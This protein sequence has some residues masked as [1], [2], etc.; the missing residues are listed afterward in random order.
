[1]FYFYSND[2]SL[3]NFDQKI[4]NFQKELSA[5]IDL[6]YKVDYFLSFSINYLRN[7]AKYSSSSPFSSAIILKF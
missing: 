1:M 4:E 7:R 6:V 5:N 2:F 3:K